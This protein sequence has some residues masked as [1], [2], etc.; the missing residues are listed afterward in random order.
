MTTSARKHPIGFTLIELLVVIAIIAILASLLS[1]ALASAK[2]RARAAYCLNNKK[3]LGLVYSLYSEDNAGRLVLN[4]TIDDTNST[5]N[6]FSWVRQ[7]M[8]W[9][10]TED[11]TP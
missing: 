8:R 3:Q 2:G 1:V 10:N 6:D 9:S 4:W 11:V 5:T 7:S